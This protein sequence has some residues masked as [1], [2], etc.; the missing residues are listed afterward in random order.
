MASLLSGMKMGSISLTQNLYIVCFS[1][2]WLACGNESFTRICVDVNSRDW[3]IFITSWVFLWIHC[4]FICLFSLPF[5]FQSFSGCFCFYS[6]G[7]LNLFYLLSSLFS[8]FLHFSVLH[9]MPCLINAF[10]PKITFLY[11]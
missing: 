2:T 11:R 7:C 4:H 6:F 10:H 5:L 1:Y 8:L 9:F 3:G